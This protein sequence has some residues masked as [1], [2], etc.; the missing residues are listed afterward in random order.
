MSTSTREKMVAGAAD[1]ISRRGVRATTMRDV[2]LHTGT[3]RGSLAHHF[4][5]GKPQMLEDALAYATE[6]VALPLEAL[7]QRQ[8]PVEGLRSFVGWWRRILEHSGFEAGCPVLAVAVEPL[9]D[10]KNG[11]PEANASAERLRLMAHD[12]FERWASILAAAFSAKGVPEARARRLGALVVSSIE[13]TVAMCR[14]ARSVQPLEDVH[15]ELEVLL[16][17]ATKTTR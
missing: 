4:P 14:A 15:R 8:G 11:E 17:D 13:G 10:S 5:G 3:P 12:A 7:V 16:R 2:V 1:L 6:S 9:L